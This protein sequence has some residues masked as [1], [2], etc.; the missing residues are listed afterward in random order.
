[1]SFFYIYKVALFVCVCVCVC[2]CLS[3]RFLKNV[4]TDFHE[5]FHGSRVI[6]RCERIKNIRKIS[7]LNV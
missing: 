2:V 6:A 3:C 1:V 4:Q 7:T 5:T